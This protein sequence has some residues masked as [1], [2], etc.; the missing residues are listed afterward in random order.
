MAENWKPKSYFDN[1]RTLRWGELLTPEQLICLDRGEIFTLCDES[2]SAVSRV[3]KDSY[4][5][6]REG[7]VNPYPERA[8]L[9]SFFF[10]IPPYGVR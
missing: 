1:G 5:E 9:P 7:A 6:I 3:L 4:G 10:G 8:S 2:G